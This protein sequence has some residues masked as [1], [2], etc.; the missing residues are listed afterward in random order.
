MANKIKREDFLAE[1][2][3]NELNRNWVKKLSKHKNAAWANFAKKHG[4]DILKIQED[5]IA[6]A[7]ETGQ[8]TSEYKKVVE[9][10]TTYFKL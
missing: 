3:G 8:P 10:T 1:Y 5:I 6:I 2:A 4:D 9:L 7:N